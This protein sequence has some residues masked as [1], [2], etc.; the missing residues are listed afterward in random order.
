VTVQEQRE[1]ERERQSAPA[2]R[3]GF[4]IA[5]RRGLWRDALLRRML[6]LGDAVAALLA[7]ASLGFLF[8]SDFAHLLWAAL[9]VPVWLLLAKLLGLYDRDHRALR[10][11]TVDE[12]PALFI[13]A[14]VGTSLLALVLAQSPAGAISASAAIGAWVIAVS[15][16]FLLRAIARMVWRWITPPSRTL[17]VG[18][19]ALGAATRRKIEL[20]PDI[21]VEVVAQWDDLPAEDLEAS[22]DAVPD[23]DRVILASQAIDEESVA[24]LVT[25][26]RRRGMNLSVVPPVRGMLGTAVQLNHVADLP[27][28]EYNTWDVSR[29]TLLLKRVLDV[30]VASVGLVVLALLM[31]PVALAIR[32]DSRGP[33][34][35]TQV[36]A[37]RNGRPF[38]MRKFRTMVSDAETRLPELVPFDALRDPM[39]K[40][41]RDPRVTRVGRFLRRTSLDELPQLV[42]VLTGAMS[43]V[44][45]RPEQVE[46]VDRYAPDQLFRLAVKPGMTGPMQV[47]GRGRL[48]FEERLAVERDY[49][50]NLSLGRD[51]RILALTLS[52]VASGRGAF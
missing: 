7:S 27:V 29:S 11:V 42:N 8:G 49:I 18:A 25:Y 51:L 28:V 52:A 13:W 41:H 20:F 10:H 16:A 35:F 37:G 43:L 46:L 34:F 14:T 31:L 3:R 26:C 5:R 45:P 50:E 48:T 23:L 24:R 47:Y 9:F 2:E 40:L 22:A 30:T 12:L 44:G 33:V 21:H 32:L 15:A 4:S 6:A 1:R 39:F 17:I 38:R 36:R 19:G